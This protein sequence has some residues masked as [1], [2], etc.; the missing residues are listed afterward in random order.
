MASAVLPEWL[1]PQAWME[2]PSTPS[3]FDDIYI[4]IKN[5]LSSKAAGPVHLALL[6]KQGFLSL[7]GAA[8]AAEE[9][10]A[11]SA[12]EGA[13]FFKDASFFKELELGPV[14]SFSLASSLTSLSLRACSLAA[15]P[16]VLS[17]ALLVDLDLG[18][19]LPLLAKALSRRE[20]RQGIQWNSLSHAD[21]PCT[22]TESLEEK[23][24]ALKKAQASAEQQLKKKK[25]EKEEE[26]RALKKAEEDLDKALAKRGKHGPRSRSTSRAR[27]ST[28]GEGAKEYALRDRLVKELAKLKLETG[29]SSSSLKKEAS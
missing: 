6:A 23:L 3:L 7:W 20:R 5:G 9:E 24:E 22:S 17:L 11:P 10:A 16:A 19:C 18:P 21:P 14:S 2:Y 29:P 12:V 13:S 27:L 4:V 1:L 8:P 25:E 28:A 15:S 26:E